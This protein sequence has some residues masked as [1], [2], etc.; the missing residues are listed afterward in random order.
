[1]I[2]YGSQPLLSNHLWVKLL[3]ANWWFYWKLFRADNTGTN[4]ITFTL[5]D[6]S[7]FHRVMQSHIQRAVINRHK[8]EMH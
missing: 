4:N 6:P 7:L 1:M 3:R 8:D 5:P 2:K